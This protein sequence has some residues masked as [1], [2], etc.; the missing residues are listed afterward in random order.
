MVNHSYY[1]WTNT[2]DG[3]GHIDDTT[4]TLFDSDG[5]TVLA[6]NDDGPAGP[7]NSYIEFTPAAPIRAA[8]I[9]VNPKSRRSRGTFQL[10]ISLTRPDLTDR[11]G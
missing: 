9:Q 11:S 4:L 8:T 7:V 6:Q 3:A 5:T 2:G 1:I 10:Q